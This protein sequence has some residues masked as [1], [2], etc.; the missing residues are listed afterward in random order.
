M[1]MYGPKCWCQ[2]L[3]IFGILHLRSGCLMQ[4]TLMVH[5]Q[6]FSWSTS[7]VCN[8]LDLYCMQIGVFVFQ[9]NKTMSPAW[10]VWTIIG[11][12]PTYAAAKDGSAFL[13]KYSKIQQYIQIVKHMIT[14]AFESNRCM[15]WKSKSVY[16]HSEDGVQC[17]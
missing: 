5:S 16:A 14:K 8:Y 7:Q 2:S 6:K 13:F 9:Y 4:R 15:H 1:K 11:S 10:N 3:S 17:T 12:I